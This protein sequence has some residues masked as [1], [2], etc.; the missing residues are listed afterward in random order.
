MSD[1]MRQFGYGRTGSGF[2]GYGINFGFPFG[3]YRCCGGGYGPG[4]GGL[5]GFGAYGAGLG[6]G[7]GGFGGGYPFKGYGGYGAGF[8]GY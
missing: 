4:P 5:G 7:F 3:W 1:I 2:R 6:A 8:Y